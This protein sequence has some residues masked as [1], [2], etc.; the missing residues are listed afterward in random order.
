MSQVRGAERYHAMP[1]GATLRDGGVRFRVWAPD[2]AHVEVVLEEGPGA[3][4]AHPMREVGGGFREADVEEARAGTAYRLRIDGERLVPDPASRRQPR[5]VHGPSL[6]CDPREFGWRDAGWRGRPFSECVLYELHVG[7]FTARGDYQGVLGKLDHLARVG[8]TAIELMPIA[9][10]AGRRNWGYDGVL[11]FAPAAAYG[12]PA[13]LKRLVE[14]AHERE[15]MVFLDVVYNHFGPEGNYLHAYARRFFTRRHHTP[16]GEAIDFDGPHSRIVRDFFIHNALYWIEEFGMDGLRL[17]AVHAIHDEGR[18][19]FL[20]ELARAVREGPGAERHVHLVVENH[21]NTARLLGGG[22]RGFDAQW[23]EDVHHALHCLLTGESAGYYGDFAPDPL[24]HLRRALEQG[25]AWQGESSDYH[26]GAPR[27]E[28]SAHLSP[29]C[30]VP[31]LQNHDQVGNRVHADRLTATVDERRLRAAAAI[32]LL[33]PRVP[34]LFMGEEFGSRA[35]FPFFCDFGPDLAEAVRAGR[36]REL[37]RLARG[38]IPAARVHIPDP[39]APETLEQAR[40]DWREVES[41]RG[42][43]FLAFYC[44]ALAAR[45]ELVVPRRADGAAVPATS[46]RVGAAGLEVSW[47]L[48][49]GSTLA[50]AANLGDDPCLE[51]ERPRGRVLFESEPGV[52]GGLGERGLPGWS[53]AWFLA[54]GAPA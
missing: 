16:W 30:F 3:G 5:G 2:A 23:D 10:F 9:D 15:L 41:E 1:F 21:A 40:L 7:A 20:E 35:P 48:D 14:A 29:T 43:R 34:L 31:F 11:P 32:V 42:S 19:R 8:V 49:D 47:T 36:E 28:P 54:G 12:T 39:N 26:G 38:S 27:G 18:P 22:G 37:V 50:L 33:A 13:D 6:V 4:R 52:V 25:F 51:L 17:D 46:R 44:T 24:S 53:A 45:N